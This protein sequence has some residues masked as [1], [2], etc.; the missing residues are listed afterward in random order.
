MLEI[1]ERILAVGALI[2]SGSFIRS[3]FKF[4]KTWRGVAPPQARGREED[5]DLRGA[6]PGRRVFRSIGALARLVTEN[7]LDIMLN[8][9]DL[10]SLTPR[11]RRAPLLDVQVTGR[12]LR[13]ASRRRRRRRR[14]HRRSLSFPVCKQSKYE[15]SPGPSVKRERRERRGSLRFETAV[16]RTRFA[17]R[18]FRSDSYRRTETL[19]L[20]E[21]SQYYGA[22]VPKS[23]I[24]Q[25]ERMFNVLLLFDT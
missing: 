25:W 1:A 21:D 16:S 2:H 5:G 9:R 22:K 23:K 4:V 7:G 6:S 15:S 18:G 8:P 14:R 13:P 19:I 10:R 12:R 11:R 17:S 24:F 20:I 3:D